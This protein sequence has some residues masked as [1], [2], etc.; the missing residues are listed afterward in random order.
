[1]LIYDQDWCT[2]DIVTVIIVTFQQVMCGTF[3]K[4]KKGLRHQIEYLI[5]FQLNPKSILWEDHPP[6]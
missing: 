6:N 2:R 4:L 1:M 5:S 3:S